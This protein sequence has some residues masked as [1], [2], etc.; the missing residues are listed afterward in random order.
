MSKPTLLDL[1]SGAG[2]AARGY[3]NA[4]F[5]VT[6]VDI[7]PQKKYPYKF[8]QADALTFDLA[9]YDVIHASPPCQEYSASRFLRNATQDNPILRPMLLDATY[10]RLRKNNRP[11][12]IENVAGAPMPDAIELCGSMFGL[13]IRRHRWFAS[14]EMI[15]VPGGCQHTDSCIN[16]IGGKVRGYGSLASK[17]TYLDATGSMRKREG[18]LS[19]ATGQLAMEIDWMGMRELSQAIPP[20]YTRWIAQFLLAAVQADCEVSA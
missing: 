14:S 1:F 4:G 9:G 20:A 2:G 12:V 16:P 15:F 11:W 18:Y 13:P 19:L 8:I 7:V 17:K 3:A 5:D 6:G 10:A